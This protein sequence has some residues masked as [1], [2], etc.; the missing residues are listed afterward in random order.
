[1]EKISK[2]LHKKL[3]RNTKKDKHLLA[4]KTTFE[5]LWK[6]FKLPYKDADEF[7]YYRN[8]VVYRGIENKKIIEDAYFQGLAKMNDYYFTLE[9][10]EKQRMMNYE[11]HESLKELPHFHY[12]DDCIYIPFFDQKLNRIYQNE[13]VL[14]DLKQYRRIVHT[15]DDLLVFNQYGYEVYRSSFSS[16]TLI[17]EYENKAALYDAYTKRLFFIE[18]DNLIDFIT[19][20][21]NDELDVL[22]ELSIAYFYSDKNK[23]VEVLSISKNIDDKLT[24]KLNKILNRK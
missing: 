8:E 2:L 22:R 12:V 24:K 20:V 18:N 10:K 19:I 15:F 9:F 7:D 5:T 23:F 1:M 3:D 16:L 14:F 4:M 6:E 21:T 13:I 11:I 17:A